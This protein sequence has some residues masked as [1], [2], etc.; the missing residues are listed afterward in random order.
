MK[1]FGISALG[2]LAVVVASAPARASMPEAQLGAMPSTVEVVLLNEGGKYVAID[3]KHI[4]KGEKCR[5]DQDAIVFRVGEGSAKDTTRV[6][7]AM[8]QAKSGG[9]PFMTEFEMSNEQFA[10][11]EKSFA[12]MKQAADDKFAAWKKSIE[13]KLGEL[14]GGKPAPKTHSL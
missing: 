11:A 2:F 3:L 1:A 4:A 13:D 6:R 7:A 12:A 8:P 10:A 14:L 9:C 5:M